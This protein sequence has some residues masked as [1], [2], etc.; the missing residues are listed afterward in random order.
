[1]HP[2]I[3][4]PCNK[5]LEPLNWKG[6]RTLNGNILC[7]H[8]FIACTLHVINVLVCVCIGKSLHI[9]EMIIGQYLRSALRKRHKSLIILCGTSLPNFF[10]VKK[11]FK[12]IKLQQQNKLAATIK[13]G[14][15]IFAVVVCWI[16][17][18]L[19]INLSSSGKYVSQGDFGNFLNCL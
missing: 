17:C 9:F 4:H 13:T 8:A 7:W 1:M 6:K 2:Y 12:N 14:C 18:I 10:F 3:F 15:A 16:S 19:P 5:S 11:K